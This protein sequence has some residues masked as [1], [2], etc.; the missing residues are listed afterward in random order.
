MR[1]SRSICFE[2]LISYESMSCQM[3]SSSKLMCW[4]PVHRL[5]K[6]QVSFGGRLGVAMPGHLSVERTSIVCLATFIARFPPSLRSSAT[7]ELFLAG[8]NIPS[9]ITEMIEWNESALFVSALHGYGRLEA[10]Y[11][12]Y[13]SVRVRTPKSIQT[14]RPINNFNVNV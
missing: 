14:G 1:V 12:L 3:L 11:G 10:V 8:L 5:T 6:R 2:S 9:R 13:F 7:L 4:S